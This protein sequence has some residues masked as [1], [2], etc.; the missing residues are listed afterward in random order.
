VVVLA[1]VVV[2]VVVMWVGQG[3][4]FEVVVGGREGHTERER[5]R[6]R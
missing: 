4:G 5:A 2:V 1:V 6:E 3:G